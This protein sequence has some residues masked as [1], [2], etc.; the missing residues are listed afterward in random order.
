MKITATTTSQNGMPRIRPSIKYA[1]KRSQ[2][3]AY[4]SGTDTSALAATGGGS[5]LAAT[6]PAATATAAPAS[7]P[8]AWQY[9]LP[10]STRSPQRE[11]NMIGLTREQR[12]PLR[13]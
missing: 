12:V 5:A 10:S 7:W 4:G 2:N 1:A 9:R 6:G 8:Q 13:V 3:P 11:Q